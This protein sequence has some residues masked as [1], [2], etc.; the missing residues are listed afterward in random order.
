MPH[1][2][3]YGDVIRKIRNDYISDEVQIIEFIKKADPNTGIPYIT[4]PLTGIRHWD[5]A[6]YRIFFD[7][8]P[9]KD[10]LRILEI[11]RLP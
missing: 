1:L 6:P 9:L 7:Y 8:D 5:F 4:L 11:T 3:F 2:I 10:V